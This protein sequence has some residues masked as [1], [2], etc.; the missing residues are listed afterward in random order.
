MAR[1]FHTLPFTTDREHGLPCGRKPGLRLS[2]QETCPDVLK[3]NVMCEGNTFARGCLCW[4][5]RAENIFIFFSSCHNVACGIKLTSVLPVGIG[6]A[7]RAT[8]SGTPM[9]TKIAVIVAAATRPAMWNFLT[10]SHHDLNL[11]YE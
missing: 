1:G 2:P 6:T 7:C 3:A 8:S 4:A 10:A 11:S 9:K 5:S